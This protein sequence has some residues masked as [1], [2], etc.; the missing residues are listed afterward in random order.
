MDLFTRTVDASLWTS[1]T[2]ED[3]EY[4][5]DQS[6]AATARNEFNA[7]LELPIS[8]ISTLI[9]AC[10][11][12]AIRVLRAMSDFPIAG[13]FKSDDLSVPVVAA[14]EIAAVYADV[15]DSRAAMLAS[16]VLSTLSPKRTLVLCS[17]PRW[18]CRGRPHPGLAWIHNCAD[19]HINGASFSAPSFVEGS[20]AAFIAEAT[21]HSHA[22]SAAILVKE[23]KTACFGE[24]LLLYNAVVL[25]EF[26]KKSSWITPEARFREVVNKDLK[27][28]RATESAMYM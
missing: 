21:I 8:T 19:T 17:I 28:E 7:S 22:L 2:F 24:L 3:P 18:S 20:V 25:H 9:V 26:N 4:D 6:A 12:D 1:R 13:F 14:G 11:Q 23:G 5:A 10:G 15:P 27:A 16:S